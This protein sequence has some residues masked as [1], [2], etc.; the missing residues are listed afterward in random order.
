MGPLTLQPY[1]LKLDSPNLVAFVQHLTNRLWKEVVD[2]IPPTA[3]TP[4]LYLALRRQVE[5]ELR[6][7]VTAMD[8]CGLSAVCED[9]R[10][11][12]PWP[13]EPKEA[14]EVPSA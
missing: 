8:L 7:H 10:E 3:K 9:A 6:E 5:Q 12:N 4:E 13:P 14:S 11:V 2:H 1:R